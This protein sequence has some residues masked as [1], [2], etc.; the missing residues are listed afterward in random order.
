L[1]LVL[2]CYGLDAGHWEWAADGRYA[3]ELVGSNG[4]RGIPID[5]FVAWMLMTAGV[6]T[7]YLRV[8][9]ERDEVSR[10]ARICR[11]PALI[12][13]PYYLVAA[14]WARRPGRRRY[15]AY[16]AAAPLLLAW[17]LVRALEPRRADA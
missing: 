6:C 2:D 14:T 9:G 1:D 10:A 17:S 7:A 16:S 13:L 5:N 15:L 3:R 8:T 12:L 11:W 4:R